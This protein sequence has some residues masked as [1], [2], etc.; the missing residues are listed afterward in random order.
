MPKASP[1]CQLEQVSDRTNRAVVAEG[2]RRFLLMTEVK[3]REGDDSSSFGV[4]TV[5]IGSCRSGASSCSC[6]C[7]IGDF[8]LLVCLLASDR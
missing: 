4:R 7:P 2:L 6:S 3:I 5:D 8:I 1:V